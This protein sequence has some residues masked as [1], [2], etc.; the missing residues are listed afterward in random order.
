MLAVYAFARFSRM[1][2]TLVDFSMLFDADAIAAFRY[3]FAPQ[4]PWLS[5]RLT[6][7]FC[8]FQLLSCH[9]LISLML[10]II[11]DLSFDFLAAVY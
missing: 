5:L 11:D 9:F 10:M 4:M 7:L 6:P 8:C 3:A 2:L 1:P